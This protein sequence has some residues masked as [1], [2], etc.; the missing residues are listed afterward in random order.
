MV[1]QYV[2]Y[3]AKGEV[4]KG[5]LTADNDEAATELLDYAGFKAISLKPYTPFLSSETLLSQFTQVQP[6]EIILLYRQMAMLLES[7]TDIAASLDLLQYQ[8]TNRALKK[9]LAEI[10]TDVRGG[11]QLSEGLEKHPK[12]FPSVYCRLISVGEQSG[13]LETILRQVADYMEKEIATTKSVKGALMMPAI[14]SVIA[15][16][17]VLLLIM[18]ILPSFTDLY[19]ALGAELPPIAK[20]LIILGEKMREY[21]LYIFLAVIA[22]VGITMYYIKTPKGRYLWDKMLLK[23]PLV[24]R[25][26]HLNELARFCR[27]L[28]LLYHSG[29]PLTEI[30]SLSVKSCGNKVIAEA[31]D[32]V[33][34]DMVKGEG[35]SGPMFKNPLFL[36]MMVQMVK[37]GEETG[38]LDSTLIAVANSYETESSDKMHSVIS[39][40]QPTMT[41][42]IGGM[43]GLIA[44]TLMSAMTA[45]Y[46]QGF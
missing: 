24:G 6:A 2:A 39:L 33:R 32:E 46:G 20:M 9:V 12:I 31:L 27:S 3:N 42:V 43:V 25:V 18:F 1:Y 8:V 45:M 7:G 17:V 19:V 29:L 10:A 35:L 5:K 26:R 40:I 15:I 41:L 44:M 28:S 36:P 30:M 23:L 34:A 4:V 38:S 21:G 37:V 13:D 14:T 16:G 11:N 22:I